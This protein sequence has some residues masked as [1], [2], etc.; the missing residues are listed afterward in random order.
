[1]EERSR[2]FN[3][4]KAASKGNGWKSKVS[5]GKDLKSKALRTCSACRKITFFNS[6]FCED[7]MK[8]VVKL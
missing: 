3:G 7:L 4:V 6:C 8:Q 1:M 2:D 5:N